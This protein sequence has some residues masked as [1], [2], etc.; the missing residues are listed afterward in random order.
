M[1]VVAGL[2]KGEGFVIPPGLGAPNGVAGAGILEPKG[3]AV[4]ITVPVDEKGE[5]LGFGVVKDEFGIAVPPLEDVCDVARLS[6]GLGT[7]YL[8][9]SFLNNPCS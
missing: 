2:S 1:V 5:V 8:V 4:L 3:D 7:L 6:S 9:A